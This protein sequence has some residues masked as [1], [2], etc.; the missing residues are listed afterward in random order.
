MQ[1][2]AKNYIKLNLEPHKKKNYH[3]GIRAAHSYIVNSLLLKHIRTALS[4][5]L[6]SDFRIGFILDHLSSKQ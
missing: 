2:Y 4:K 3:H 1:I 6:R 5:S